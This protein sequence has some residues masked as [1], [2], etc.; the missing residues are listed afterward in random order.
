MILAPNCGGTYAGLS[1]RSYQVAFAFQGVLF[2]YYGGWCLLSAAFVLGAVVLL[3]L[4]SK[5]SPYIT[6]RTHRHRRLPLQWIMSRL[7]VASAMFT[8]SKD[9]THG[10][11]QTVDDSIHFAARARTMK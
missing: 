1:P 2:W 9:T 11:S 6:M 10:T 3:D 4:C 5:G 8:V 7:S